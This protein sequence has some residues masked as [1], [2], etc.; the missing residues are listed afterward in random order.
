MSKERKKLK[1]TKLG[2]FLREKVPHVLDIVGNYL[3]ND[4]VLGIVKNIVDRESKKEDS[5]I[6]KEDLEQFNKHY[7]NELKELELHIENTKNARELQK[8]ALNQ[9]DLFSKRF[10]YIF[11]L[12]IYLTV[13][14]LVL[15]LCF[16]DIP[17]ENRDLIYMCLGVLMGTGISSIIQFFFGSSIGSKQKTNEIIKMK[18]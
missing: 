5:K 8:E 17:S 16:I 3:P 7:E 15:L 6:T 14:L 10:I 2:V 11:S 13:I 1:D 12:V 9:D 4:G 18:Q